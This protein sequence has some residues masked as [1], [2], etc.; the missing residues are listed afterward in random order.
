[1]ECLFIFIKQ[2][3]K[4]T[5]FLKTSYFSESKGLKSLKIFENF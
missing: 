1:M 5:S 4:K 3:M 2:P